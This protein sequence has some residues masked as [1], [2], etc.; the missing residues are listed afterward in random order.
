MKVK[1]ILIVLFGFVFNVFAGNILVIK[2]IDKN[3]EKTT[4]ETIYVQDGKI[5]FESNKNSGEEIT[6]INPKEGTIIS[7]S[8]LDSTYVVITK[9]DFSKIA[10][11]IKIQKEKMLNQLPEEE[12]K[13]MEAMLDAQLEEMKNQPK[14]EYK[15]INEEKYNGYNCEV[16]EGSVENKK[17][18]TIWLAKWQNMDVRDE[19]RKLF[20]EMKNFVVEISKNFGEFGNVIENELDVEIFDK[21]FPVKTISY[22]NGEI[23]STAVLES[24]KEKEIPTELFNIPE[25]FKNKSPFDEFNI[26]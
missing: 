23:T 8:P 14:T 24:V 22:E 4:V 17:T 10:E 13:A 25:G 5:R 9:D 12:R 1:V 6:I 2:T 7:I 11:V 3:S 16:L 18:E 19:Y 26:E 20:R 15:K 21:G